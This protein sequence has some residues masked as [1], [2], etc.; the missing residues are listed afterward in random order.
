MNALQNS[1]T[2]TRIKIIFSEVA[3]LMSFHFLILIIFL[4]SEYQRVN[5]YDTA[6]AKRYAESSK[7]PAW[8]KISKIPISLK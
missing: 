2:N 5:L 8:W 7:N 1:K 4:P 6:T 3:N